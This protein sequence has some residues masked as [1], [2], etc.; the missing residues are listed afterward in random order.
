MILNAI[1]VN[2]LARLADLVAEP[3]AECAAQ[4]LRSGHYVLGPA[5]AGFEGAFAAYCGVS[6]CIGV[7]N[8]TDALEIALRAL[9][10]GPGSRVAVVANAGMYGT[11]AVLAIGAEPVFVD[12]EEATSNMCPQALDA[13]LAGGGAMPD[14]IIVTHL[15]GR[16]ADMPALAAIARTRGV[17]LVEDCA[18]AH[19][20]TSRDGRKAGAFGD[21]AAFS[22]YPTK[23]LG[24]MGDGGAIVTNDGILAMRVRKLRQ[25]GWTSKYVNALAGGRNSRLDEL[26]AAF[27]SHLLP[28]LDDRNTL[29]RGIAARYSSRIVH[30]GIR[31]PSAEGFDYVAHLYVVQVGQRDSLTAHLQASG[32]GCD[33]HYPAPDHWQPMHA[34][35]FSAVSLPVTEMLCQRVLTLPCFPEMHDDEVDRVIAACND[36]R[37]T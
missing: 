23:N 11:T 9:G 24:A 15:Y 8:G 19:G 2:D 35:R 33:V 20:A 36:W 6:H 27:L 28:L 14:A 1:P 21:L 37:G 3:L 30:P 29:R 4:V 22:F 25:Y 26:Q 32:I 34:G 12:V 18:Q 7:G 17:P 10:L 13:A 5:V 16:M 31:V